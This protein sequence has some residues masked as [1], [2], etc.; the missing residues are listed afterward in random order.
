MHGIVAARQGHHVTILER[1]ANALQAQVGAGLGVAD[2]L[3]TFMRQYD[4]FQQPYSLCPLEALYVDSRGR[5]INSTRPGISATSWST[6]YSRL[7][8]NFDGSVSTLGQHPGY[9]NHDGSSEQ[10]LA[11]YIDG[12]E[13]V[14]VQEADDALQ[15]EY[16]ESDHQRSVKLPA[17][18]VIASDGAG[19]K[20]RALF[21]S[22][23]SCRYV[24]YAAWRGTILEKDVKEETKL[25]CQGNDGHCKIERSFFL[26]SGAMLLS[27]LDL[28]SF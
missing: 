21:A 10:E 4:R 28:P 24:G 20:C 8:A 5:L 2:A 3:E 9:T 12:A 1:S 7:R 6:L 14:A 17:D 27:F 25:Q 11:K 22:H 19:S 16:L 18:L 26:S 13:V 23:V 15:V